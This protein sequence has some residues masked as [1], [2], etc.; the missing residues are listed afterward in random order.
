MTPFHVFDFCRT[1]TSVV[2]AET[3]SAR[4]WFAVTRYVTPLSSHAAQPVPSPEDVSI[5]KT[6][7]RILAAEEQRRPS[8]EGATSRLRLFGALMQRSELESAHFVL[9]LAHPLLKPSCLL[10]PR[11]SLPIEP[12]EGNDCD[13]SSS[14]HDGPRITRARFRRREPCC[15]APIGAPHAPQKRAS[16]RFAALHT[17]QRFGTAGEMG[18]RRHFETARWSCACS[19]RTASVNAVA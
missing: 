3:A 1:V 19:L 12:D 2:P 7:R 15:I 9:N 6:L 18:R 17:G 13:D 4:T 16:V 8:S 11:A 14:S 10:A 5:V